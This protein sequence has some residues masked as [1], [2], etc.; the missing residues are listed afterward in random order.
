[1]Y[2]DV[3]L[4]SF[5]TRVVRAVSCSRGFFAQTPTKARSRRLAQGLCFQQTSES[6]DQNRPDNLWEPVE[7]D[8]GA[9]AVF[10]NRAQQKSHEV[11]ED[12][13]RLLPVQ[14]ATTWAPK[15]L[16]PSRS[17]HYSDGWQFL[18]DA[19]V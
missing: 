15:C 5:G 7:G 3:K 11:W 17:G 1:M 12:P 4:W 8:H 10:D 18:S 6:E 19:F 16:M 9:H 13:N 2:V 14:G